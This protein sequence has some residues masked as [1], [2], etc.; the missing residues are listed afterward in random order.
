[1]AAEAAEF[2]EAV[3]QRLEAKFFLSPAVWQSFDVD[4]SGQLTIDEF[5]EG[6]KGVDAYQEFRREKVPTDILQMILMD[7]AQKLFQEVDVNGD[8]T[9]TADE[10]RAAFRL[11][12][13][14]AEKNLVE[15]KWLYRA[16]QSVQDQFGISRRQIEKD[17]DFQKQAENVKVLEKRKNI[18]AEQRKQIEWASEVDKVEL[19]DVDMDAQ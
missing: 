13:E 19:L 16:M 9:L 10:L 17:E 12:R 7:F 4:A 14:E 18:I 8:G 5:V 3:M 1:M 2:N 11:R 6:M 15:S